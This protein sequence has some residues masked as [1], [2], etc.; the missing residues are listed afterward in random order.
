MDVNTSGLLALKYDLQGHYD[1][2]VDYLVESGYS[3]A[4][5]S[6]VIRPG[7]NDLEQ[8][9]ELYERHLSQPVF[10]V[11]RLWSPA[12]VSWLTRQAV[13]TITG[14]MHLAI[15]SLVQGTPAVTFASQGKVEGMLA[16][17]GL[18]HYAVDPNSNVASETIKL[19]AMSDQEPLLS[20]DRILSISSRLATVAQSNFQSLE[21]V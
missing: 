10:L 19:I 2:I 16:L 7:D 21:C 9:S 11:N 1:K 20:R 15:L 18:E 14:R 5:L 13:V 6:H 8:A 17:Y 3:V 4:I 12:N